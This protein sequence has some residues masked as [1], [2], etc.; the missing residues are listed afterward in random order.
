MDLI[1]RTRLRDEIRML[2]RSNAVTAILGPRQCGKTTLARMMAAER[3]SMWLDCEDLLSKARLKEPMRL[4]ESA[5]G[6]VVID[7]IQFMP[8]LF[9]ILR[10]LADRRPQKAKFLILG[11]TSPELATQAGES[12]A[13][14]VAY[15]PISGFQIDEVGAAN[16]DR[17]WWRGGFPRAYLARSAKEA[18]TWVDNFIQTFLERD[19]GILNFRADPE[20]VRR[21]WAMLAHMHGGKWNAA[22]L[23]RSLALHNNTVLSYFEFLQR[24]FMIRVV[25]PW[26]VNIDKR[27]VKAPKVYIRDTGILHALLRLVDFDQLFEHPKLGYSW[28]GFVLEELIRLVGERNVYF[29]AVHTGG[30]L[31]FLVHWRGKL[32]GV[33]VKRGDAPTRTKSMTLAMS[34]LKLDRLYVVYPGDT[35]YPIGD[36][37]EVIPLTGLAEALAPPRSRMAIMKYSAT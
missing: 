31:D 28:E 11:S 35:P 29:W 33:E 23:S 14:R 1:D 15:L 27:E 5:R 25:R 21:F 32:I 22:E 12:L 36:N 9:P 30:E 2:I 26:H 37:M 34:A 20:R 4:L 10:V 24:A 18:R 6:L 17:L 19:M 7:E 8:E 3:L 16:V 13:G